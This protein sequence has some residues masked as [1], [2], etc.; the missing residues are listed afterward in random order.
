MKTADISELY[1]KA[2]SLRKMYR[3]IQKEADGFLNSHDVFSI[4]DVKKY[5]DPRLKRINAALKDKNISKE[6]KEVYK[7]EKAWLLRKQVEILSHCLEGFM[8]ESRDVLIFCLYDSM[9]I[10]DPQNFVRHMDPHHPLNGLKELVF[11]EGEQVHHL[12]LNICGSHYTVW[13]CDDSFNAIDEDIGT[14]CVED[15]NGTFL[16]LDE[17]FAIT[18]NYDE[19]A[20]VIAPMT[21]DDLKQVYIFVSRNGE[22]VKQEDLSK[23]SW[24][25]LIEDDNDDDMIDMEW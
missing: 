20:D 25:K 12:P 3:T 21:L 15:E 19:K 18:G 14:I 2:R 8:P 9:E 7:E 16:F 23:Y 1:R 22:M 24:K 17:L 13:Y 10:Y 5:D 11:D 4:K 6:A